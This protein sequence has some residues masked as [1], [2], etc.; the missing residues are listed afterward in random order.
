VKSKKKIGL[1]ILNFLTT[2]DTEVLLASIEKYVA[3]NR[4]D[5]TI[6]I[7][8]NG[9]TDKT[10]SRLNELENQYNSL[11]I[12]TIRSVKNIGFAPG[13]NLGVDY[14]RGIGCEGVILSNN[15]IFFNQPFSLSDFCNEGAEVAVVAPQVISSELSV[16]DNPYL[17][18]RRNYNSIRARVS[19][20]LFFSLPLVGYL[21]YWLVSLRSWLQRKQQSSSVSSVANEN[22][23]ADQFVY[24]VHGSFL[25][26]TPRY[27]ESY[28]HLDGNTFLYNEE[29]ILAERVYSI[30]AVMQVKN[31]MAVSHKDDSSTNELLGNKEWRKFMFTT[32]ENYRSRKYFIKTYIS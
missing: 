7:V 12:A 20:F 19:R 17:Y 28:S 29:L 3:L 18:T 31:S 13:M 5:L 25:Y 9:S 6:C 16:G 30:D 4:C 24:A 1:V 2:K 32:R 8:D 23:K 14:L 11:S 21:F 22:A 15:D 10:F 27:F 26:L